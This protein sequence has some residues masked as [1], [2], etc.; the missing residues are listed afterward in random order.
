MIPRRPIGFLLACAAPVLALNSTFEPDWPGWKDVSRKKVWVEH[1]RIPWLD[2]AIQTGFEQHWGTSPWSWI[3]DTV[4]RDPVEPSDLRLHF[5]EHFRRVE[6][7]ADDPCPLWSQNQGRFGCVE[8]DSSYTQLVL[9][10]NNGVLLAQPS[11]VHLDR[12]NAGMVVDVVRDFR[13]VIDLAANGDIPEVPG[14]RGTSQWPDLWLNLEGQPQVHDKTLWVPRSAH[15]TVVEGQW[16]SLLGMSVR[17]VGSDSLDRMMGTSVPGAYLQTGTIQDQGAWMRIRDLS[18]GKS[19]VS[20]QVRG[21]FHPSRITTGDLEELGLS[22]RG[23]ER[24][25]TWSLDAYRSWSTR[26]ND[27]CLEGSREIRRGFQ[28]MGGFCRQEEEYPV[29][30]DGRWELGVRWISVPAWPD[31][32]PIL[33]SA[34][35]AFLYRPTG[36]PAGAPEGGESDQANWLLDHLAIRYEL[37]ELYVFHLG[38]GGRLVGEEFVPSAS[39]GIHLSIMGDH[40]WKR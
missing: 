4:F 15:Q 39:I 5:A 31:G 14:F 17:L 9:E 1:T 27:F 36:L 28:A 22:I 13:D 23:V 11:V 29:N 21:R 18:S 16:E 25:E 8:R 19:L 12:A 40:P 6:S 10:G 3:P 30:G 2:D 32:Q 26:T 24:R 35:S 20:H 37:L 38:L 34:L 33:R 7:W